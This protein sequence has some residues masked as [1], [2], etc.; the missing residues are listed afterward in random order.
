MNRTSLIVDPGMVTLVTTLTNNASG[1]SVSEVILF[2]ILPA[3]FAFVEIESTN[4][5]RTVTCSSERNRVECL[6]GFVKANETVVLRFRFEIRSVL[7]KSSII[8]VQSR[9][10][11]GLSTN[12]FERYSVK[13]FRSVYA[14]VKRFSR[15]TN[16][17]MINTREN[18]W[19]QFK[20]KFFLSLW[21]P[22]DS[23]TVRFFFPVLWRTMSL[24]SSK[25]D[26]EHG[27]A[28][29]AC[30][31]NNGTNSSKELERIMDLDQKICTTAGCNVLTCKILPKS[32]HI[33]LAASFSLVVNSRRVPFVEEI[34]EHGYTTY[35]CFT[36][37]FVILGENPLC[38]NLTTRIKDISIHETDGRIHYWFVTLAV[39]MGVAIVLL[40]SFLLWKCGFFYRRA[41][42]ELKLR[43]EI[44][45]LS[46]VHLLSS[47]RNSSEDTDN[48]TFVLTPFPSGS[49]DTQ[50]MTPP[51]GYLEATLR[52]SNSSTEY[53]F[54]FDD[55][56][57]YLIPVFD[58][59]K[60][61][62]PD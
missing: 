52:T 28:D 42:H 8:T 32:T 40:L 14:E 12:V 24:S 20:H 10:N 26:I 2:Q 17:V 60:T 15:P 34:T 23:E 53:F 39:F 35:I 46:T 43:I 59:I 30:V 25:V 19:I 21:Y 62:S 9:L 41:F 61:N 6:I 27:D 37:Q 7:V 48:E 47:Q 33:A 29:I 5:N 56:D 54:N 58:S 11:T 36:S 51:P 16:Y 3:G 49:D 55:E 13:A 44:Q 38:R 45:K 50:V 1:I 4:Q 22:E 57:G 18:K 31:L